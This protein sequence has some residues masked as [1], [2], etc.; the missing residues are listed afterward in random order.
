M[1]TSNTNSGPKWTGAR[2]SL[3]VLMAGALLVSACSSGAEPTPL[4]T[5]TTPTKGAG[6]TPI[7]TPT[8]MPTAAPGGGYVGGLVFG[9]KPTYGGHFIQGGRAS[10]PDWN[11]AASGSVDTSRY[12]APMS[13]GLVYFDYL[14]NKTQAIVPD[15]AESWSYGG[16]GKIITFKLKP[17]IKFHNGQ[18][19]MADD[20]VFTLDM[21]KNFK[22]YGLKTTASATM[23]QR[24]MVGAEAIDP[25]TVRV[26]LERPANGFMADLADKANAIRSKTAYET[27]KE[28]SSVQC[29]K[30]AFAGPF[31]LDEYRPDEVVRLVKNPNYFKPGLPFLDGMDVFIIKDETARET[32]LRTGRI[33]RATVQTGWGVALNLAKEQPRLV[34]REQHYANCRPE[35]QFNPNRAP[36]SDVRVRKAISLAI[37]RVSLSRNLGL[38]PPGATAESQLLPPP[39]QL[40]AETLGKL[41]GYTPGP[42][43]PRYQEAKELLRQAGFPDGFAFKM[44]VRNTA[45]ETDPAVFVAG[46]LQKIGLKADLEIL[47]TTIIGDRFRNRDFNFRPAASCTPVDP[48]QLFYGRVFTGAPS[49]YGFSH[50]DWDAKIDVQSQTMDVAKR[51]TLVNEMTYSYLNEYYVAVGPWWSF[52][53]G[54][55]D[56]VKGYPDYLSNGNYRRHEYT[57]IDQGKASSSAKSR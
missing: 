14:Q 23:I 41:A 3:L 54:I 11:P 40:P 24:V 21:L 20:V 53:E 13:A 6:A 17:G 50:P 43:A 36:F 15:I 51:L 27:C 46:E 35:F 47:D 29:A 52:A 45:L 33:H 16:A 1:R 28:L 31:K 4:R 39:F 9:E 32:A 42:M 25:L 26:T 30:E 8:T 57:W 22:T 10:P 55:W 18:P 49:N 2:R 48:D 19:V 56:F 38:V 7:S 34:F 5:E 37:D 44:Q 12:V